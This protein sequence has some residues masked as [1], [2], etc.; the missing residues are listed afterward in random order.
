MDPAQARWTF[1]HYP[2]G[3][4]IRITLARP[5]HAG[6]DTAVAVALVQ[7]EWPAERLCSALMAVEQAYK[8]LPDPTPETS[9]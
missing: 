5:E 7:P 8:A 1:A 2:H 3:Y 6:I 4:G 9:E